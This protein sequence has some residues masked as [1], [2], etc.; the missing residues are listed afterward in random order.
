VLFCSLA[1]VLLG[2]PSSA[3]VQVIA[4]EPPYD[5][6]IR[7]GRVLDGAGNPWI[8]ADIAIQGGRYVKLGRVDGTG[9]REIDA[10]GRY[11]SPGWIDMMDQSDEALLKNGLAENKLM[12]GV[13]TA[14]AG[15]GG[16]PVP[17]DKLREYW[18]TLEK[19][20]ISL[21]FGCYY[22]EAQ[23]RVDVLGYDERQPTPEELA[24]MKA[25]LETAMKNGAMGM[26]TAL[27]YPPSSY[28]TTSELIE[29]AKVASKY[30]GTYASHVRGEGKE[31]LQSIDEL[32]TISEKGGL[33]GR[34][35]PLQSRLQPGLGK[36][37][38][39]SGATYR[40]RAGQRPGCCCGPLCVHGRWDWARCD[41]SILGARGRRRQISRA[42]RRPRNSRTP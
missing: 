31:L 41:N 39:G 19:N 27:I 12:E 6:V 10:H 11:V 15:E 7:G 21:N 9:R 24:K 22:S 38:A 5:V 35:F 3:Q 34:S 36:T 28:A 23:A 26:T 37:N 25:I 8:S 40:S 30:G 14:I 17:A 2:S 16:T 13:T 42:T 29:M 4:A 1:A 18:A 32:I 33:P 20:G